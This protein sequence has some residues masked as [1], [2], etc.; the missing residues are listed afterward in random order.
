MND[1]IK[2]AIKTLNGFTKDARLYWLAVMVK[3]GELCPAEAGYIIHY[4]LI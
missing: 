1:K 2:N 4:N 3:A